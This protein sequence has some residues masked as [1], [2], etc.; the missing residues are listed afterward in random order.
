MED[1]H[2]LRVPSGHPPGLVHE[3]REVHRLRGP[4]QPEATA[5]ELVHIETALL[6]HVHQVEDGLRFGHVHVNGLEKLLHV[7]VVKSA[8]ELLPSDMTAL[9]HVGVLEEIARRAQEDG[10]V[11]VPGSL[12]GGLDKH[13][14]H[15]VHH[16]QHRKGH[17]ERVRNT[18]ERMYLVQKGLHHVHP[19]YA[20]HDGAIQGQDGRTQRTVVRD[21]DAVR[22]GIGLSKP[23]VQD[24]LREGHANS[25]DQQRHQQERPTER[26]DGASNG[27][28][29]RLQLTHV[30][31][32][33][34][35]AEQADDPQNP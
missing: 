15:N 1:G 21:D 11:V 27:E 3:H 4:S 5:H 28:H 18:D 2:L 22:G 19:V 9:I 34:S 7:G 17:V 10:L 12:Q 33:A 13:T 16:G 31:H 29:N 8:L 32:D 23:V 30:L 25:V 14:R 24:Q 35:C 26:L 20:P 6:V